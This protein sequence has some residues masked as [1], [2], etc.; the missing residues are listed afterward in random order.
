MA[1]QSAVALTASAQEHSPISALLFA[2]ALQ[3]ARVKDG[4]I[5]SREMVASLNDSPDR[6]WAA[7]R[8]AAKISEI[9][10]SEQLRPYGLRPRTLRFGATTARGYIGE[11]FKEVFRRYIPRSEIEA[12]FSACREAQPQP[13][14]QPAA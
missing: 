10:L 3:F 13:A 6:P 11:E 8:N 9:W 2:M 1:R 7:M 5:T 12:Y 4:R 14:A